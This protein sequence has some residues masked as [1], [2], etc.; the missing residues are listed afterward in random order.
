MQLSCPTC[1]HE[2]GHD[3][4]SC[5]S[6]GASLLVALIASVADPE[7]STAYN[8]LLEISTAV[9]SGGLSAED[10]VP[11]WDE[12]ESYLGVELEKFSS[13]PNF[14]GLDSMQGLESVG[15]GLRLLLEA[16]RALRQGQDGLER[17]EEGNTLLCEGRVLLLE[18]HEQAEE[19]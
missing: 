16:V 6:C 4:P 10:A 1:G 15:E 14:D 7:R 13:F 8:Q 5:P 18:A 19:S 17:A 2:C 9:Q 3:E 11:L 12:L